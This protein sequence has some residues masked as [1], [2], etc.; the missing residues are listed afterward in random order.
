MSTARFAGNP[1]EYPEK[2]CGAYYPCWRRAGANNSG[3]CQASDRQSRKCRRFENISVIVACDNGPFAGTYCIEE[4]SV[5]RCTRGG[6]RDPGHGGASRLRPCQN[7]LKIFDELID[8]KIASQVSNS[9]ATLGET[10]R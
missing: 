9:P 6:P 4:A 1:Y 10:M 3:R 5:A 2:F 7:G 8:R